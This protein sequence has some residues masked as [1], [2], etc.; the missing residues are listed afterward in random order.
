[1][2]RNNSAKNTAAAGL[3]AS[4]VI[5]KS[6]ANSGDSVSRSASEYLN[7]RARDTGFAQITSLYSL[8]FGVIGFF[9]L[10]TW[11]FVEFDNVD[12]LVTLR[13]LWV[14]FCAL[15]GLAAGVSLTFALFTYTAMRLKCRL[16]PVSNPNPTYGGAIFSN[17]I[18][19]TIFI[20]PFRVAI[21]AVCL[22]FWMAGSFFEVIRVI[23]GNLVG[24]PHISYRGDA[25]MY[26][27][28][29][30]KHYAKVYSESGVQ[31]ANEYLRM[32]FSGMLTPICKEIP[33]H[34]W[35]SADQR[36][37]WLSKFIRRHGPINQ[38]VTGPA[39]SA[40]ANYAERH[41][42]VPNSTGGYTY[43][44]TAEG[45]ARRPANPVPKKYDAI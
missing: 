35:A 32:A 37:A 10:G 18:A 33:R 23:G 9:A 19:D 25:G 29:V 13:P 22:P 8:L 39:G 1:M 36:N 28:R 14:L 24:K 27:D 7:E 38:Y 34:Q 41:G 40:R 16:W 26:Y 4:A 20:T 11:I 21:C 45:R 5:T 15:L 2:P 6:F 43:D 12:I 30:R 42:G 31:A 44:Y 3:A 17:I